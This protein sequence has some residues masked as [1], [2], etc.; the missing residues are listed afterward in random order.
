[1]VSWVLED[2]SVSVLLHCIVPVPASNLLIIA[3]VFNTGR[4][5][6]H[7]GPFLIIVGFSCLLNHVLIAAMQMQAA[8]LE[9]LRKTKGNVRVG[10]VLD[11]LRRVAWV[12]SAL[13]VALLLGGLV[14][15][16]P[17][18]TAVTIEVE[19]EGMPDYCD[20]GS[21]LFA[22]A[23]FS[24]MR[25]VLAVGLAQWTIINFGRPKRDE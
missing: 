5:A 16:L 6:F 8:K 1:M 7:L 17:R 15:V 18:A 23:F 9:E 3:G 20:R 11:L 10:I 24:T 25:V 12:S 4:C 2:A 14:Y 21:F 22:Q 19:D 13:H